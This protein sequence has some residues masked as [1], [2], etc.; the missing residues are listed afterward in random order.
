MRDGY[1]EKVLH[2]S[3]QRNGASR[4]ALWAAIL[5][6]GSERHFDAVCETARDLFAVSIA[7]VSLVDR[8]RVWFKAKCGIDVDGVPRELAFC[9]HTIESDEVLVSPDLTQDE[10]F[11][12][13]SLVV[14][15]PHFRFYAGAPL[16]FRPGLRL[17]TLCLI[18]MKPRSFSPQD[19]E[20][21]QK[22]ADLVVAHLRL[23]EANLRNEAEL[24]ARRKAEIA[25]QDERI[26]Y[27]TSPNTR[28]ISSSSAMT[29]AAAPTS[30]P[31][32][33]RCSATRR[34]RRSACTCAR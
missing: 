18:D 28:A 11:R 16:I 6:T 14:G 15:E 5:D 12:D 24:A 17:G 26:R 13:N 1:T 4:S 3:G 8:D 27:R 21:L 29:T 20:R 2:A 31:P 19:A 33:C 7:L 9:R 30:P 34:T 32:C 23:N 10:R 25:L 22:L